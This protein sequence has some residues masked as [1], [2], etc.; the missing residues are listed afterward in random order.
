MGFQI[1]RSF[2]SYD[3]RGMIAWTVLFIAV[4]LIFENLVFRQI[5]ADYRDA[6]RSARQHR[7]RITH[8]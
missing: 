6:P 2:E 3:V 7:G 1:R 8:D 4:M 5:D